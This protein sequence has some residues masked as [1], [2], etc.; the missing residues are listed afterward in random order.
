MSSRTTAVHLPYLKTFLPIMLSHL[1]H[2][3]VLIDI[4]V[5][6][7]IALAIEEIVTLVRS[8][9]RHI[10]VLGSEKKREAVN[11]GLASNRLVS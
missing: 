8:P 11:E 2:R 7:D 3:P 6:E 4:H 10:G 1:I 9:S 5:E